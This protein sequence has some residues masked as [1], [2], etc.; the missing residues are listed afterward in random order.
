[1]RKIFAL[2]AFAAVATA[3]PSGAQPAAG[4]GALDYY[5]GTWACVGGPTRLSQPAHVT[6]THVMNGGVLSGSVSVPAQTGIKAP[7]SVSLATSYDG[8]GRYIQT[9]LDN[10]G[11]WRVSYA[12]PWT[13]NTERWTDLTTSDGKLGHGETVRTDH[14][15]YTVTRYG[16]PTATTPNF[17]ATCQRQSS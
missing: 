10:S 4:M 13:G 9:S 1:M 11:V 3:T 14:E 2:F 8:K 6:V 12:K 15:H 17:K 5:V 16:T 7:I